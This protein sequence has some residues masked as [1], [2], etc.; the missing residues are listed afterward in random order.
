MEAAILS[1]EMKSDERD[2]WF[3]SEAPKHHVV[4]TKPFYM[5]VHEVTQSAYAK[6]IGHN[7]SSW[8]TTGRQKAVVKSLDTSKYPVEWVNWRDAAKFCFE[9]NQQE[10][11]DPLHGGAEELPVNPDG[12]GY[13]LPTEAEW[14]FVCRAGTVSRFWS[15]NSVEEFLAVD[16]CG[17]NSSG[18]PQPTGTGKANPFGLFN[19]HGNVN[20]CLLDGWNP[21]FYDRFRSVTAIDPISPFS[22]GD[23][24][25]VRGGDWFVPPLHCRSSRR[26]CLSPGSMLPGLA[27][28]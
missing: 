2:G 22:K 14:E 7:P 16:C 27:F 6:V 17:P 9:L 13:R 4:L 12:L 15:G 20:E 21:N 28:A 3:R 26:C 19:L 25:V 11:L 23:L 8:S 10:Q 5:G 18:H 24:R 1:P